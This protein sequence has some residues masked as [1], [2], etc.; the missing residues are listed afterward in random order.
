MRVGRPLYA[1]RVTLRLRFDALDDEARRLL[2]VELRQYEAE[3]EDRDTS[4][5]VAMTVLGHVGPASAVGDAA[6]WLRYAATHADIPGAQIDAVRAVR[7]WI[8][9]IAGT[10]A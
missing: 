7:R 4:L 5:V 3:V 8:G 1:W 6:Q 9:P 2:G 10:G